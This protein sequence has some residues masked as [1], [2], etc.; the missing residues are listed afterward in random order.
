MSDPKESYLFFS[1][2]FLFFGKNALKEMSQFHAAIEKH[3]KAGVRVLV[4]FL[5][6]ECFVK[7]PPEQHKTRAWEPQSVP[8][9]R[10]PTKLHNVLL[11]GYRLAAIA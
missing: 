3:P 1:A 11:S 4:C 5:Q 7:D 2:T 10:V 9:T 6:K 8:G